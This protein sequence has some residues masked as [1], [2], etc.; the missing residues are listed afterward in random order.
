MSRMARRVLIPAFVIFA[1]GVYGQTMKSDH[2]STADLQERAKHLQE[3]AAKSDGSA[4]ETLEQYPHHYTMLAFRQH[5]GGGELHQHFADIFYIL[6]GRASVLTGGRLIEQKESGPGEIRG[7]AV[8]GGS[9]QELKAGD[10]VHIP[11]G[12]PHQMLVAEGESI[13]YYVVKVEESR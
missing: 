7:K 6:E 5:S 9:R 10:V 8:E 11:A 4:S 12:M 3:L 2:W 1:M 13:T